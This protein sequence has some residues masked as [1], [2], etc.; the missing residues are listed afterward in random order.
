MDE[1]EKMDKAVIE[2]LFSQG[3]SCNRRYYGWQGLCLTRVHLGSS[4]WESRRI[5]TTMAPAQASRRLSLPLKVPF[6][7]VVLRSFRS[8]KRVGT[9]LARI[10]PSVSVACDVHNTL[11]NVR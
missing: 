8:L 5:L 7:N 2:A 11:V 9:E 1:N 6:P 3:V 4:S 10:D